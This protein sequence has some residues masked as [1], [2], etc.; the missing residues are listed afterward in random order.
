MNYYKAVVFLGLVLLL[1]ISGFGQ[2]K[3]ACIGDSVTK[4]SGLKGSSYPSILQQLLGDE[5]LVENFGH[6]GATLLAR[7]HN[8]YRQTE[9]YQKALAFAP[10]III[11]SL[12]LNDT[13]PRN[14]PNY[15]NE[16]E[17]DYA[18]LIAAFRVQDPSVEVYICS[19]TPI[20]SGH[21]RFL[22]GTRDWFGQIQALIPSVA[23]ANGAKHIDNHT[24]LAARIDLFEDY[25]HPNAKGNHIIAHNIAKAMVGVQQPLSLDY[26][27]GSDMIIQRDT[28]NIIHGTAASGEQ[29][30]VVIEDTDYETKADGFGDWSAI[31]P[32]YPAGGPYEI[33]VSSATEDIIL[34]NVL[35]GDVYLASG[36]SNMAFPLDQ[37]LRGKELIDQAVSRQ[38]DIRLFK[39]KNLSETANTSWDTVILER[40]NDLAYFDGKWEIPSL[41]NVGQFSAVAYAFA[42]EIVRNEGVPVGIID[43]SVGGSNTESWISRRTLEQ[44]NLLAS[45]IH[46]WR[47]SDFIQTFCR[48]RAAKNTANSSHKNQRHPYE[49]AYNYEAGINR[50]LKTKFKAVLWY[51][52]ESNAHNI[53]LHDHLF[54]TLVTSWRSG[55]Q[56]RLPFYFVQLSSMNRPSW[57]SFRDAQ[58]RLS[59]ELSHVYMAVSSD[60][61]DSL[62]VHPKEKIIIG[63]RL[64]NLV[65]QHEYGVPIQAETPQP[66]AFI[67]EGNQLVL[68][69]DNCLSLRTRNSEGLRGLQLLDRRGKVIPFNKVIIDQNTLRIIL[70]EVDVHKVQYA[71]RPYTNA[72]LES[73]SGVPVSTFSLTLKDSK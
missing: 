12:G 43:L 35:F 59:S 38:M 14:W 53:E 22:S 46:Q 29:I 51:Q 11:I 65:R 32:A 16:F 27:W 57:P 23:E 62:D 44:D 30:T 67:R 49:P 25:L 36:Q 70:R 34:T 73:D 9:E 21:R 42:T 41:T 10:D 31:L 50:W 28:E 18:D 60:L 4:G 56:Q 6:N 66:I 33:K 8:P 69:F 20:F 64:A 63:Q 52:G 7:G 1:Q 19:M 47:T 68:T 55:F 45:Y 17:S 26:T 24:I 40:V 37:A 39:N 5:Y 15:Q 2:R 13:D 72:N 58:R 54:R 71:Y 48:E 3:V 61:G